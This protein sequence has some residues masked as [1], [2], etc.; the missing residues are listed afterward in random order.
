MR[1]VFFAAIVGC[2]LLP[3]LACLGPT[4][5][6][7]SIRT[8]APC[9][10]PAR[11]KGVALYVGA[12]GIDVESRAPTLT[13]AACDG[14]GNIGSI[15][16]KPSGANDA[17]L[18]IRVVAGLDKNPEDCRTASYAGCIVSRRSV[19]YVPHSSLNLVVDL[20][21]D[22]EGRGCDLNHTCV[23]GI[24]TDTVIAATPVSDDGGVIDNGGA[25]G[26][27]PTGPT[28]RCGNTTCPTNDLAHTCCVDVNPDSG[29][30]TGACIPSDQCVSPRAALLCDEASDCPGFAADAAPFSIMSCGGATPIPGP[31]TCCASIKQAAP[32]SPTVNHVFG[33]Q[34][35]TYCECPGSQA[36]LCDDHRPCV[37]GRACQ[38]LVNI[39][40]GYF[41]CGA[42]E[43]DH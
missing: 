25:E 11:W 41:Y 19:K 16:I 24:C 38:P 14:D 18:G 27:T 32:G 42:T 8:N 29:T 17:D 22:C 12:P 30:V 3:A 36:Q 13:T 37:D 40:P 4:E 34:C 39:M 23:S 9:T 28:V 2:A 7:V 21:L 26:G 6:T 31:V 1:R 20:T 35:L 5:V 10:D 33:A 43:L 15:V